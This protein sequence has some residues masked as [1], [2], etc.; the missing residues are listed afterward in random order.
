MTLRNP[1]SYIQIDMTAMRRERML[2]ILLFKNLMVKKERHIFRWHESRRLQESHESSLCQNAGCCH[3]RSAVPFASDLPAHVRTSFDLR[4]EKYDYK[5][6]RGRHP[7]LRKVHAR[8]MS[9]P[10]DKQPL[11]SEMYRRLNRLHFIIPN[12]PAT[13][14]RE[15]IRISGEKLI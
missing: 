15:I 5:M 10:V 3:R 6:F 12:F 8:W 7:V 2:F 11:L 1:P 14:Y 13:I 9:F 4:G